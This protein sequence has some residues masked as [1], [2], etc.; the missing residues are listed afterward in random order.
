[1]SLV[2]AHR[3][4]IEELEAENTRLI[5]HIERLEEK[6]DRLFKVV[7]SIY[8]KVADIQPA[9]HHCDYRGATERVRAKAAATLKEHGL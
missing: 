6:Y 1:M 2:G 8:T 9:G 4:S 5:R 7:A 3:M